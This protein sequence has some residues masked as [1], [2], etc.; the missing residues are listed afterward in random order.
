MK[1][2][3]LVAALLFLLPAES[4]KLR[5]GNGRLIPRSDA[6][7][8][9]WGHGTPAPSTSTEAPAETTAAPIETTAAP[10]EGGFPEGEGEGGET[11]APETTSAPMETSAP[12][13]TTAAPEEIGRAVQQECRDRSRMPSSA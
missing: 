3:F 6:S 12:E 7:F 2:V 5:F 1:R 11:Q 13:E 4:A 10:G 9:S 8:V